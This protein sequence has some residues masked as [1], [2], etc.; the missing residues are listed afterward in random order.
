[1]DLDVYK[2]FH[3]KYIVKCYVYVCMCTATKCND[4]ETMRSG[5]CVCIDGFY[6][7]NCQ[8]RKSLFKPYNQHGPEVQKSNEWSRKRQ[9]K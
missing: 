1:M 9:R 6:G 3:V 7:D 2:H 8:S 4:Y 5:K